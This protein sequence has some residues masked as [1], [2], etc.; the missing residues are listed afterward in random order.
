MPRQRGDRRELRRSAGALSLAEV[1]LSPDGLP[2]P[3]GRGEQGVVPGVGAAT[4]IHSS[5]EA[6]DLGSTFGTAGDVLPF[7]VCPGLLTERKQRENVR[8]RMHR[9][10][11]PICA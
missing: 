3:A 1:Q 11:P 9:S 6:L 5:G 10:R 2:D 7:G 8:T 4:D